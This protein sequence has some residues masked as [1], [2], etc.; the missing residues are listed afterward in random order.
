MTL[1]AGWGAVMLLPPDSEAEL[2]SMRRSGGGGTAAGTEVPWPNPDAPSDRLH[3]SRQDGHC[4]RSTMTSDTAQ[5]VGAQA[6]HAGRG[7]NTRE[8]RGHGA[9]ARP[10]VLVSQTVKDLTAGSGIVF[11]DVGEHELKGVPTAGVCTGR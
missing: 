11:E 4:P 6:T 10:E 5:P 3:T 7:T 1:G 8:P 2:R 9:T